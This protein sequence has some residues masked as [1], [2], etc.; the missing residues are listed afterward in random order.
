[1]WIR[2]EAP[3]N[4][5]FFVRALRYRQHPC[6]PYHEID[7]DVYRGFIVQSRSASVSMCTPIATTMIELRFLRSVHSQTQAILSVSE[8]ST[9]SEHRVLVKSSKPQP[10]MLF[11]NQEMGVYSSTGSIPSVLGRI[12]SLFEISFTNSQPVDASIVC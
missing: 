1:M 12:I 2:A 3:G 9:N 11:L 5:H 6:F 4:S 7:L 8:F 10:F